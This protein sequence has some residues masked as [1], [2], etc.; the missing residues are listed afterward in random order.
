MVKRNFRI[1]K[2]DAELNCHLTHDH[3][4]DSDEDDGDDEQKH[5][6]TEKRFIRKYDS[7]RT[8][9]PPSDSKSR[10]GIIINNYIIRIDY[11][12]VRMVGEFLNLFLKRTI[13]DEMTDN[14]I[15]YTS[16]KTIKDKDRKR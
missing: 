6:E 2:S 9:N 3:D 1:T 5:R 11:K 13:T 15:L 16:R 4:M 10:E 14:R 12:F 8:R 7:T